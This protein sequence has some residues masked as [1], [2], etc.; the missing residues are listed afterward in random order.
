[1]DRILNNSSLKAEEKAAALRELGLEEAT[2]DFLEM[3]DAA[4]KVTKEIEKWK[5]EFDY[6]D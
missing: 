2:A 6:L 4:E 5:T 1:M 3:S